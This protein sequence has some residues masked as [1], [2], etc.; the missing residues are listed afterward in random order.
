MSRVNAVYSALISGVVGVSAAVATVT[1]MARSSGKTEA[2]LPSEK[3]RNSKAPA[4]EPTRTIIIPAPDNE[5]FRAIEQRIDGLSQGAE[6]AAERRGPPDPEERRRLLTEKTNELNRVHEQEMPDPT[7]SAHAEQSLAKG[8][9]EVGEALG[10]SLNDAEC[11]ATRCR[12]VVQWRDAQ[13]AERNASQL[14][15]RSF[16][17]LN[18]EQTVV[19]NDAPDTRVSGMVTLYLDCSAQRAGLVEASV[20]QP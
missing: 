15:E 17:G 2:S 9:G 12:A 6:R 16:P 14:A 4:T 13:A 11:K 3:T 1:I 18:C 19:R 20:K 7:W 8:L 10:F 5:R